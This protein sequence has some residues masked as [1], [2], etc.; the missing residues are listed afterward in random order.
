MYSVVV[1]LT[2]S[3]TKFLALHNHQVLGLH[4]IVE[5]ECSNEGPR[6]TICADDMVTSNAIQI[7]RRPD[8]R[9]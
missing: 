1:V 7:V 6:G 5:R 9:P 8:F 3:L 4:H 2:E